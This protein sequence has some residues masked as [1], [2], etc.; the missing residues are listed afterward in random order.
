[1]A[2]DRGSPMMQFFQ[3]LLGKTSAP[4]PIR[5]PLGLH[6]NAGFT[7]DTLAFRLLES[8]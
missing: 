4:A 8:S 3:R 1:M 7:L 5:G 6:L 2:R